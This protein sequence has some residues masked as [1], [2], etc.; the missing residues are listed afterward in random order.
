MRVAWRRLRGHDAIARRVRV[1]V[2]AA[3]VGRRV[4]EPEEEG[5]LIGCP[6][7]D[8]V[9]GLSGQYVLLVVSRVGAVADEC[10]VLDQ[11][12]VVGGLV[13]R[14][15]GCVPLRPAGWDYGGVVAVAVQILADHGGV[16]ARVLKPDGQVVAF[17]PACSKTGIAAIRPAIGEDA[18]VV[19]VLAG[20]EGGPGG[21]AEREV[22][23]AVAEPRPLVADHRVDVAHDPHRFDRLIV[24]LDHEHVGPGL[25]REAARARR[26][27]GQAET[28][29]GRDREQRP[30]EIPAVRPGMGRMRGQV[31][32]SV[33]RLDL[34]V[35]DHGVGVLGEQVEV[36]LVGAA[37][38][39]A[40]VAVDRRV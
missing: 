27:V 7:V 10:A 6:A 12:V 4:V 36:G 24:G 29:H 39:G 2:R 16:V 32:T 18:V 33:P 37:R 23:E 15:G 19:R 17:V 1:R 35:R 11:R 5:L 8:E 26:G 14:G 30:G 40:A 34:A 25:R 28:E 9:D 38:G 22:D 31:Q 20:E 21:T 13:V 3:E